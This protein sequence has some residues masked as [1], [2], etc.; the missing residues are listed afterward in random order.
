MGR[1]LAFWDS[2]VGKKM[3]MAV[4]GLLLVAFTIAHMAGNLQAFVG[5]ERFDAY[6]R[7]LHGPLVELVWAQRVV[8]LIATVLHVVAAYQLTMRNR[9]ARPE[10]YTQLDAQASTFAART[11]R[12]G[13]VILLVFIVYH[14]LHITTGTLHPD[15]RE[16]EAYHNLISGLRSPAVAWFYL[17]AMAALALH[18]FH[19]VWSSARSLGAAPMSANPLKR[20][21]AIVLAVIIAGGF[22][23]VPVAVMIG[24]LK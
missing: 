10:G 9:A 16:G 8:L 6:A 24:L 3:V 5:A 18:L 23:V 12:I 19:G 7:L 21:V 20:R 22:A 14:L 4:T 17:L 11:L 13:G 2:S 1:L 15:F